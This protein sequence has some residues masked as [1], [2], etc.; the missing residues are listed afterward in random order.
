MIGSSKCKEE[1][2]NSHFDK[3]HFDVLNVY[4]ISETPM[5]NIEY[6]LPVDLDRWKESVMSRPRNSQDYRKDETKACTGSYC[7]F[8]QSKLSK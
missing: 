6:F 3:D 7:V 4:M 8:R 1:R 5:P 2:R